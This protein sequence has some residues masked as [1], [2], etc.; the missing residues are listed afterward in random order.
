M[1][2]PN[3][4]FEVTE[5]TKFCPECGTKITETNTEGISSFEVTNESSNAPSKVETNEK[6]KLNKKKIK[7]IIIISVAALL[8]LG[9]TFLVLYL[10]NPFCM[11]GHGNMHT[12]GGPIC[13]AY[14]YWICDDCGKAVHTDSP[15]GHSFNGLECRYCGEKRS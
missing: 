2:C 6:K 5:N 1:K 7:K 10:V 4:N 11:F 9:I 8:V 12:E 14:V 3:C 15:R 13:T